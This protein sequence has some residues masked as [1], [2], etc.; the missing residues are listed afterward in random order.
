MTTCPKCGSAAWKV[1]ERV[2]TFR[3]FDCG[4]K[5]DDDF[6]EQS[7]LCRIAVLGQENARLRAAGD[8]LVG[9]LRVMTSDSAFSCAKKQVAIAAWEATKET[10]DV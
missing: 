2:P 7:D 8:R 6:L 4:S 9:A 1:V 10:A 5:G 3:Y